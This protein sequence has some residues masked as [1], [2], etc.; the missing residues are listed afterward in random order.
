[1]GDIDGGVIAEQHGAFDHVL[2]F[3]DVSRPIVGDEQFEGFWGDVLDVDNWGL[4]TTVPVE[5]SSLKLELERDGQEMDFTF[6]EAYRVTIVSS[7]VRDALD[8][9]DGI[10]LIPIQVVS[11]HCKTD[12]FVLITSQLVECVDEKNSEGHL[13]KLLCQGYRNLQSD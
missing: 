7:K 8:D 2:Q 1:M 12:Y 4:S 13:K 6:T 11:K 5:S 10:K 9:I 3:A